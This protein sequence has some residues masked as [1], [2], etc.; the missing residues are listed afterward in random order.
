MPWLDGW[1][2]CG[3]AESGNKVDGRADQD[4]YKL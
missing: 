3:A 1:G 4:E 2:T